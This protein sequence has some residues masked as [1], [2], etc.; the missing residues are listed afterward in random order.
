MTGKRGGGGRK[1]ESFTAKWSNL[2]D[3]AQFECFQIRFPKSHI[4]FIS[5]LEP[6]AVSAGRH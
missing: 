6:E 4:G 5:G 3:F 1:I 2:N